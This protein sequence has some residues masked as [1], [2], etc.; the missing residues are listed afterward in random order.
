MGK[1]SKHKKTGSCSLSVQ[2][3]LYIMYIT[4]KTQFFSQKHKNPLYIVLYKGFYNNKI[5]DW[6][7]SDLI[8]KSSLLTIYFDEKYTLHTLY[9][10]S[11][12]PYTIHSE[13][14]I[15][16]ILSTFYNTHGT[17]KHST[18]FTIHTSHLVQLRISGRLPELDF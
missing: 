14:L 18:P 8:P 16:Y 3:T 2:N 10:T 5:L 12:T 13:H 11:C 6:I 7:N 4:Q 15:Q 9:N 17:Q 1:W